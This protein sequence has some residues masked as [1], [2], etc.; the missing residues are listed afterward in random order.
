MDKVAEYFSKLGRGDSL[1]NLEVFK[2]HLQTVLQYYP[3]VNLMRQ[4][5]LASRAASRIPDLNPAARSRVTKDANHFLYQEVQKL[6]TVIDDPLV[7]MQDLERLLNTHARLQTVPTPS[8]LAK[9]LNKMQVQMAAANAD[10]LAR[11]PLQFVE[12]GVYP[13]DD[14]IETWWN[15]TKPTTGKWDLKGGYAALYRMTLLD[16][17]RSEDPAI[18]QLAPSPCRKIA[19]SFLGF[20]EKNAKYIFPDKMDS[21]VF[22]AAKWFGR[23]FINE[24]SIEEETPRSSRAEEVFAQSFKG[25]NIIVN[26]EGIIVPQIGH[27]IDFQLVNGEAH[28]VELD[29]VS[30]FNRIAMMQPT[31]KAVVFNASTRFQS[32]LMAE[33]CPE[34]HILRIPYFYCDG[35]ERNQPWEETLEALEREEPGVYAYHGDGNIKNMSEK[36]GYL[37]IGQPL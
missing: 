21:Q 7:T 12:L 11:L 13:G 35:V 10:C 19:D 20:I 29:G 24:F 31:D 25:T 4:F 15:H 1:V 30:H 14:W 2:S 8:M 3:P 36:N 5:W 26:T 9:I 23:D 37:Y 32:W 27:K 28:G 16:F 34:L 33:L 17:L 6:E 22:F 18:D